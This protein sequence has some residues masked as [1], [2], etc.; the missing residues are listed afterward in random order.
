MTCD[1][2]TVRIAAGSC[3]QLTALDRDSY[4]FRYTVSKK[5]T[6]SLPEDLKFINLRNFAEKLERLADYLDALDTA[7]GVLTEQKEEMEFEYLWEMQSEYL[8]EMGDH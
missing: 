6:P 3:R 7:I 4:S 5:G 2:A 8:S 1:R